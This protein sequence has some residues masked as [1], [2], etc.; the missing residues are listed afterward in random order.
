M[1]RLLDEH[2]E[3]RA[4]APLRVAILGCGN[5][6]AEVARQL[7]AR[8]GII[9]TRVLVRDT[10]RPRPVARALLTHSFDEVL[11]SE[12]EVMIELLGGVEPARACIQAALR[13]G[14]SVITANKSIIARHG[15]ALHRLAAAHGSHLLYEAAVGAGTPILAALD[16]LRGDRITALRGIVNGTCNFILNRMETTGCT[17]DEALR[18]AQRLG[19][20]EPDPTADL[21][22]RDSAEKLCVLAQRAGWGWIHPELVATQGITPVTPDDV[23]RARERRCVIRLVAEARR[24]EQ[25][26]AD[27]R[28]GPCL[29]PVSHPLAAVAGCENAFEIDAELAGRI[30]V[31]GP[32]AGPRATASAVTS[33]LLALSRPRREKIAIAGERATASRAGWPRRHYIRAEAPAGRLHPDRLLAA[34]RLS[35]VQPDSVDLGPTCAV[36]ST[37]PVSTSAAGDLARSLAEGEEH[38]CLVAPVVE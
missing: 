16:Q 24:G 23:R 13:R 12:P 37:E 33:D 21:T 18:E 28:V 22:G 20:A 15:E 31:Q 30:R 8:S 17:L 25:G 1:I 19:Y 4:A 38:R 14:I 7:A 36:V 35:G 6:G 9:I 3:T 5:V 11:A 34:I 2:E 29:V 10:G 32:G 27:L 26:E